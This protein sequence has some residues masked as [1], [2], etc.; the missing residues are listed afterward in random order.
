MSGSDATS[1]DVSGV[2][3][4][5]EC[6]RDH[7]GH[8]ATLAE[9]CEDG[10]QP[11]RAQRR[12]PN[13]VYQDSSWISSEALLT[14]VG[15]MTMHTIETDGRPVPAPAREGV[16][17]F[18]PSAE[19]RLHIE[20]QLE[21][22][23]LELFPFPHLI[24]KNFFPDTVYKNIQTYNLFNKNKGQ[25]WITKSRMLLNRNTTPYDHRMQINFHKSEAYEAT[26]EER[27]FWDTVIQAF[28]AD[29]W[30]PQ[31]VYKKFPHYFDIR[32]GELASKGTLW[33]KLKK[34]LFLQRHEPNYYIGPHTDIA[35]R[36][37][38]CIFSF[39]SRPGFEAYGTQ[40]LRH[41]D[42]MARCWG[43]SHYGFEDFTVE[44]TAEYAPN[45]FL[46]FFKTRQSFHAVKT[47]LEAVPN[48]RWG[49]QFQ[50][51]EPRGG[52]FR[53][54]SRPELMSDGNSTTLGRAANW[55]RDLVERVR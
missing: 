3:E 55:A 8:R 39:A 21:A 50:C 30:F 15:E 40:L 16:S 2:R 51:Y 23:T 9:P 4:W 33:P 12:P 1:C 7:I 17:P 28:I 25:A 26:Q 11:R 5:D 31:I 41:K 18:M 49:M 54:L 45:N 44:K 42:P 27:G 14:G 36:I 47:I 22:A 46:L 24:I 29:D 43:D 13:R 52:L 34:Q 35:T 53:E 10:Q 38:T 6:R 19:L 48:Q 20:A 37:F 32:F